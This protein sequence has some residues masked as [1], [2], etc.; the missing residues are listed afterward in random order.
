MQFVC[1]CVAHVCALGPRNKLLAANGL[2]P[3]PGPA[4][5]M[6]QTNVNKLIKLGCADRRMEHT[7]THAV[8]FLPA[9]THTCTQS[10]S[11]Y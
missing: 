9:H 2:T 5:A 3:P 11:G 4:G 7:D 8:S 6:I 1:I 10:E